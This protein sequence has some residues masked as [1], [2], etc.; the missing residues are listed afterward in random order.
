MRSWFE[1]LGYRF[2]SHELWDV[3]YFEWIINISVRCGRYD[4]VLIRGIDGEVGVQ[5]VRAIAESVA[6]HK[7]DEG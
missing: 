3:N 1:T 2:E 4:R 6:V 7:V 5:D